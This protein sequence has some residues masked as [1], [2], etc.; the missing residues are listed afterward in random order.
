MVARQDVRF[1]NQV[2]CPGLP[3]ASM[4]ANRFFTWAEDRAVRDATRAPAQGQDCGGK[5]ELGPDPARRSFL[6]YEK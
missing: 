6:P 1:N 5:Y 3:G 2:K 4:S